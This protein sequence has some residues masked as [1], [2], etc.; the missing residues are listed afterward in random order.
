MIEPEWLEILDVTPELAIVSGKM[1]GEILVGGVDY[2]ENM[3]IPFVFSSLEKLGDGYHLG[4]IREDGRSVIYDKDYQLVF[5]ESFEK[6]SYHN[7]LLTAQTAQGSYLYDMSGDVP[8]LRSAKLHCKLFGSVL[9][10]KISNQFYLS[11]LSVADLKSM[12]QHVPA[13]LDM[14]TAQDFSG[15]GEISGEEYIG[16]LMKQQIP[17]NVSLK[18]ISQFWFSQRESGAYDFAFRINYQR[19]LENSEIQNISPDSDSDPETQ[20]E[21][22]IS[23]SGQAEIHCYFRRNA[24]NKMILTAADL[25]FHDDTDQ[26]ADLT[27]AEE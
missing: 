13:Y 26:T 27:H 18:E 19:T 11:S 10:W 2:E 25:Q 1:H 9:N 20:T 12:N 3:V 5:Q 6:I 22:P 21:L 17:E 7:K 15:L 24:E 4:I 23:V 16:N 8:V 14:L